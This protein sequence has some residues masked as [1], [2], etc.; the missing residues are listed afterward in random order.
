MR[1]DFAYDI[2]QQVKIKAIETVGRVDALSHNING[3]MYS[4]VFWNNGERY[5]S[6]MFD[7]EIELQPQGIKQ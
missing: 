2:G 7:W 3:Q 4:V 1:V 6:W 5:N